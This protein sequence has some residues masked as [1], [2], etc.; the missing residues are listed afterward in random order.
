MK[1]T[2]IILS[3]LLIV[4]SANAQ[5]IKE[6]ELP[7]KVKAAFANKYP[8]V[9]AEK[10]EKENT[11]YE[12]EFDLN[13]KES[14]A[15]FDANGVF[16]EFEQEIKLSD[17]PKTAR[18]YCSANFSNYKLSETAE[19]TDAS[20]KRMFEAELEKGESHVDIIFDEHGNFLKKVEPVGYK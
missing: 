6:S 9:K 3:S 17:L 5:K 1:T 15:L 10:W 11:D 2:L 18:D 16:K 4:G 7:A 8:G 19:I 20:G 13:K 14:S 12:V